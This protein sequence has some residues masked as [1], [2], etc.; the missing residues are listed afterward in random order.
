MDTALQSALSDS[1]QRFLCNFGFLGDAAQRLNL[2]QLQPLP[3][4]VSLELPGHS[5]S[6]LQSPHS[7]LLAAGSPCTLSGEGLRSDAST[8]HST[9]SWKT[10]LCCDKAAAHSSQEGPGQQ[11]SSA[12][13]SQ[14]TAAWWTLLVSSRLEGLRKGLALLSYHA[15]HACFQDSHWSRD[16]APTVRP[17]RDTFRPRPGAVCAMVL[18]YCPPGSS[19]SGQ[20]G[21]AR[22]FHPTT[23]REAEHAPVPTAITSRTYSEGSVGGCH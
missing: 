17:G 1:L 23:H 18:W 6:A 22:R 14:G 7:P 20:A 19:W 21:S 16:L 4:P 13:S 3:W 15:S 11:P 12:P 8:S 10:E 9:A 2:L 5:W